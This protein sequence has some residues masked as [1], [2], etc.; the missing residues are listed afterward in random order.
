MA[1]SWFVNTGGKV[2]GPFDGAKLRALAAAGK[3]TPEMPVASS[4]TGPWTR[5]A[6]IRGL[7]PAGAP[8]PARPAGLPPQPP[9]MPV[10]AAP[11]G[12]PAAG[13]PA[14]APD[15]AA[16][17][18]TTAPSRAAPSKKGGTAKLWGAIGGLGGVAVVLFNIGVLIYNGYLQTD[19]AAINLIK[20][21]M[22]ETFAKDPSV[23]KPVKVLEVELQGKGTNRTG[24]AT[25][26]LGGKPYTITFTAKVTHSGKDLK[27]DWKTEDLPIAVGPGS[28]SP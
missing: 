18:I 16:P 10:P 13:P 6:A 4:A 9:A 1:G 25:V 24:T 5:A 12:A 14:A 3:V 8:A 2:H 7:F 20:T 17:Q 22:Q 15:F 27:V 11:V 21:S 19:A 28:S 23:A 26:K